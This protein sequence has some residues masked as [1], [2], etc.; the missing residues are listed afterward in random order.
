MEERGGNR[1]RQ[2]ERILDSYGDSL[3][4]MAFACVKNRADAEDVVQ[5]VLVKWL[6]GHPEFD[7]EEHEKA[8]LFRCVVNR[9]RDYLRLAWF[10]KRVS[11]PEELASLPVSEEERE[12]M[13]AVLELEPKYRVPICLHYYQ[14]YTI[15]EIGR[16]MGRKPATVGTWLARGR[17]R[18]RQA[19]GGEWDD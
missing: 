1:E 3:M 17:E 9:S 7:S 15:E 19:L 16:M 18:L 8:W 13:E 2:M 14:G 11:L 6:S 12:V 10:R 4:G 5:D